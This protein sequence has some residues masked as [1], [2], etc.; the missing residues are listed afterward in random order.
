MAVDK[1]TD[2]DA[3]A[4]LYRTHTTGERLLILLDNAATRS[5][6][7]LTTRRDLVT[8]VVTSRHRLP[9]LLTRHGARPVHVDVLTDTESQAP[10]TAT[11][12]RC[13]GEQGPVPT[14]PTGW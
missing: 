4:A 12:C 13:V 1:P 8:V 10:S 3:R 9:T 6:R 14:D 2:P 5:G 11:G 7:A